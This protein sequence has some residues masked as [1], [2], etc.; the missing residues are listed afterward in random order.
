M[1]STVKA[2]EDNKPPVIKTMVLVEAMV[3]L[4]RYERL[5]RISH[6][7]DFQL[8]EEKCCCKN[9]VESFCESVEL[10]GQPSR[11][12]G[13]LS[14]RAVLPYGRL[15]TEHLSPLRYISYK[16]AF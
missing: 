14:G 10:S 8:R 4:E 13:N 16:S 12:I 11:F 15:G 1:P 9:T 2:Q 7:V 5:N 6:D 3:F